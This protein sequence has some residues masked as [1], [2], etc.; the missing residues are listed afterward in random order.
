MG[1]PAPMN[2]SSQMAIYLE[3]W[4]NDGKPDAESRIKCRAVRS[5]FA[6]KVLAPVFAA[7]VTDCVRVTLLYTGNAKNRRINTLWVK[8]G[9]DDQLG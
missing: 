5:K 2:G 7:C 6:A 9:Y 3:A 1:N 4:R 8:P